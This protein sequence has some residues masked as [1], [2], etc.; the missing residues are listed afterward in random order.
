MYDNDRV[1]SDILQNKH[2][3]ATRNQE[4]GSYGRQ[5]DPY[6]NSGYAKDQMQNPHTPPMACTTS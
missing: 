6:V 5:M 1:V 4:R 2:T 3:R